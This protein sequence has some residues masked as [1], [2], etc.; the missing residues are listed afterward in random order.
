MDSVL[1]PSP[2]IHCTIGLLRVEMH[3]FCFGKEGQFRSPLHRVKRGKANENEGNRRKEPT[4]L[5]HSYNCLQLQ[6]F[7]YE[8]SQKHYLLIKWT[9]VFHFLE[10]KKHNTRRKTSWS[11]DENQQQNVN[12]HRA[13]QTIMVSPVI[14]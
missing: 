11:K 9:G 1:I 6:L 4:S 10:L 5:S 3:S 2:L 7:V 14:H 12:P 13:E 8:T